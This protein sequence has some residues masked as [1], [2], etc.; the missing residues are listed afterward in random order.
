[1]SC[2]LLRNYSYDGINR[3]LAF[4]IR[5][6]I[7]EHLR[8]SDIVIGG[9]SYHSLLKMVLCPHHLSPPKW[10]IQGLWIV[11]TVPGFVVDLDPPNV[12]SVTN[13]PTV[14][15]PVL[16]RKFLESRPIRRRGVRLINVAHYKQDLV[17]DALDVFFDGFN[18]PETKSLRRCGWKGDK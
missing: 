18:E 17:L 11:K 14:S 13:E 9:V 15:W 16:W 12:K 2:G 4:T 1:M 5:T 8:L 7:N 10:S 6:K 3:N